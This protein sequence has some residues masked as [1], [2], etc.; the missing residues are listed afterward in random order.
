ME[1]ENWCAD[2]GYVPL[3]MGNLRRAL[4][5]CG[6]ERV[7]A[8]SGKETAKIYKLGTVE[9]AELQEVHVSRPGLYTIPGFEP[10]LATPAPPKFPDEEDG[11]DE[12]PEKPAPKR[13]TS[14][15]G[16]KW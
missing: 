8:R 4:F 2:H 5:S 13:K 12:E 6:F 7:S 16:D 14:I 10:T 9:S 11:Q 15:V 3:G 1:Y